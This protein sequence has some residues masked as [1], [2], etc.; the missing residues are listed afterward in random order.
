M[1]ADI[2]GESLNRPDG[3]ASSPGPG[4]A[5]PT[6]VV[7][8]SEEAPSDKLLD[9]AER[10]ELEI[11][12]AET[13]IAKATDC[14]AERLQGLAARAGGLAAEAR[15]V[16]DAASRASNEAAPAAA[17]IETLIGKIRGIMEAALRPVGGKAGP[18]AGSAERA[19]QLLDEIGN[20]NARMR[21]T[22]E[23]M[24]EVTGATSEISEKIGGI[25]AS[26]F[27]A[28][29]EIGKARSRIMDLRRTLLS[30]RK[31]AAGDRRSERRI[32]VA[33]DAVLRVGTQGFCGRIEDLSTGGALFRPV[34]LE[35]HRDIKPGAL[36]QIGVDGVG[37]I[38]ATFVSISPAGFHLRF[39]RVDAQIEDRLRCRLRIAATAGAS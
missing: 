32:A 14:A 2:T 11:G 33:I 37:N 15:N 22:V 9:A 16:A 30:V 23:E 7:P 27:Y 5:D 25:I 38:E 13:Y 20:A 24:G 10:L 28:S 8:D 3:A 36:A 4:A 31:S 34:S 17:A 1:V 29:A 35:S 39:D 12:A 19:L 6:S 26:A 21:R 18:V